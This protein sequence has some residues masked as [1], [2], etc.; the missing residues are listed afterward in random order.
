MDRSVRMA[1]TRVI[2]LLVLSVLSWSSLRFLLDECRSLQH[3][4]KLLHGLAK[5]VKTDVLLAWKD[6][7][8]APMLGVLLHNFD[9]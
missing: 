6:S 9:L 1:R 2:I 4:V 7:L 5:V 3:D 8:F